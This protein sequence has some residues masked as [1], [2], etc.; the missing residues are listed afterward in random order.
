MRPK[1]Y[2]L[3]QLELE[4]TFNEVVIQDFSHYA[5]RTHLKF[6]WKCLKILYKT[7]N[8]KKKKLEIPEALTEAK[9]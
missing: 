3:T 7:N 5:T 9:K 8:K 6:D 4:L 1:E 2:L